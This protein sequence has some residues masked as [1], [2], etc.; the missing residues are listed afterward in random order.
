MWEAELY[1]GKGELLLAQE[2]K[3]QKAKDKDENALEA[4]AESIRPNRVDLYVVRAG[5]TWASIA[6]QTG[7][8][9]RPSTLAI[10]NN[11]APETQPAV[12]ARIKIVVA[13]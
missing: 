10:M 11:T 13:G 12:G 7:D 8:L 4:E 1:R 9:V 6:E 3:D 2:G 5:D